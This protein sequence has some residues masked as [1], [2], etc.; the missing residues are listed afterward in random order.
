MAREPE[1]TNRRNRAG[2]CVPQAGRKLAGEGLRPGSADHC[3]AGARSEPRCERDD[4]DR[5]A[6]G[7]GCASKKMNG[8]GTATHETVHEQAPRSVCR[9]LCDLRDD[10]ALHG[11]SSPCEVA[12]LGGAE[13]VGFVAA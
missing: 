5:S 4:R 7:N 1:H 10:A 8:R 6:D 11:C 13:I 12:R 2:E 9:Q 3:I